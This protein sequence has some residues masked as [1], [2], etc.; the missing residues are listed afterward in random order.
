MKIEVTFNGD[1]EPTIW[2]KPEAE[3]EEN[4]L[5]QFAIGN[6]LHR[7]GLSG[8]EY[9]GIAIHYQDKTD[10]SRERNKEVN[11]ILREEG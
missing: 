11:R 8:G 4:W 5:S 10:R 7:W 3:F 1:L 9:Q 2:V 6:V